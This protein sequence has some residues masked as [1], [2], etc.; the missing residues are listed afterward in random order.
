MAD[1]ILLQITGGEEFHNTKIAY[2]LLRERAK[3]FVNL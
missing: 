1:E 3:K 2:A